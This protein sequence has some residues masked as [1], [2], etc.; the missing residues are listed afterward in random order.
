MGVIL[1]SNPKRSS[2]ISGTVFLS[3]TFA[4]ATFTEMI[5]PWSLIINL[6]YA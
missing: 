2:A 5:A 3:S 6:S 4:G 1:Q